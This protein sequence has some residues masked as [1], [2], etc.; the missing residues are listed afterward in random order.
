[1]D[2]ALALDHHKLQSSEEQYLT[3]Q[4]DGQEYGIAILKVQEIKGWDKITPIPNSPLY[5]SG[6]LNLRGV[7]VPVIELRKRF[8]LPAAKPDAFTVIVVVNVGERLAGIVVDSVSDVIRLGAEQHCASPEYEGQ[9]EREF[10]Q[11][12]A[13]VEGRLLVLLDVDRLLKPE[14]LTERAEATP[15]SAQTS[16]R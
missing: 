10:I 5:V 7:I 14:M 9:R 4:L 12:M 1:M 8:N 15:L 11:G 2:T 16:A 3:F 13:Q 6:V